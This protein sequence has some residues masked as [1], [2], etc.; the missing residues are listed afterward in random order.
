MIKRDYYE[1]LGVERNAS[2]DGIKKAYRKLALKYHPD[3]NPGDKEAEER[4]KEAADKYLQAVKINPNL[5][6][7]YSNL[8]LIYMHKKALQK[9][10]YF[11][12]KAL[13]LD[14]SNCVLKFRLAKTYLFLNEFEKCFKLFFQK[15]ILKFFD[16][17][18][19]MLN[20]FRT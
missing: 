15:F 16:P 19:S 5:P 2:G 7:A 1:V 11:F 8:G 20:L 17:C 14:P 6:E 18:F 4:F 12:E 10:S 9:S 13:E 3:R